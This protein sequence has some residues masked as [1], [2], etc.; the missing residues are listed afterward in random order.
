MYSRLVEGIQ[1]E[2]RMN[3]IITSPQIM[4]QYV[5]FI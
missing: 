5:D 4:A 3:S 1:C 2:V